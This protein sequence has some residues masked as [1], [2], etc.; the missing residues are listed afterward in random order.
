MNVIAAINSVDKICAESTNVNRNRDME[1]ISPT[2]PVSYLYH[3]NQF[4]FFITS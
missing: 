1:D 3:S 4:R 2:S